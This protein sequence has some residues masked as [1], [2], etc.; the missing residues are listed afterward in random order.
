[1]AQVQRKVFF[2]PSHAPINCDPQV[3]L[4]YTQLLT[5]RSIPSSGMDGSLDTLP[6]VLS[7]CVFNYINNIDSLFFCLLQKFFRRGIFAAKRFPLVK[8]RRITYIKRIPLSH[9]S[10]Y[11]CERGEGSANRIMS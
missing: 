6:R 1:M 9:S 2:L 8:W 5:A 4:R 3:L 10:S 7:F 11:C